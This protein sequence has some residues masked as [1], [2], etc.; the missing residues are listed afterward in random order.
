[1]E[2]SLAIDG[3]QIVRIG[4]EASMPPADKIIDMKNL[5]VLPGLIDV[6][7]HLR[8]QGKAYKEDFYS[9]TASAAAGGFTTVLDMP[10]NEPVTMSEK[11]LC[12]RMKIASTKTVVDVGFFCEFPR[13]LTEIKGIVNAGA[14]GFKLFMAEQV[15]GLDIGDDKILMEAFGEAAKHN[16]S[17]AVHAEDETMLVMS[18]HRL[19]SLGRND[20]AAFLEAH[21]E[22]VEVVAVKHLLNLVSASG[23]RLHFCHISTEE[24]LRQIAQAKKNGMPVTCEVT[25]HHLLLSSEDLKRAGSLALTMPPVRQKSRSKA[26]WKEIKDRVVD[27]VGS[28]HAPHT[29]AEKNAEDIW[30]VKV[31]IPG[32]E[33]TLPLLLTEVKRGRL[34]LA[35]IVR[36]LSAKPAEIFGLKG[37]GKLEEG[38]SA[39]L[40]VVDMNKTHKIDASKFRSK[41][42]FSPFDGWHVQGKAVKTFVGG[43]LVMD[44]DDI[45]ANAGTGQ[46]VR[47]GFS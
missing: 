42:K 34:S 28:D 21:S 17:M 35:E 20:V 46:V 23:A 22:A 44:D 2:C 10:N 11:T 18:K 24:A 31:G 16:L 45:V 38:G 13:R 41:A 12:N 26:L 29:I 6:H 40:T 27:V 15:G 32:L 4:T 47:R 3:G 9:G 39:D 43:K 25:P 36:L 37:K 19:Q 7:V 8:D 33:T 1:M 5:L 30:N 14:V